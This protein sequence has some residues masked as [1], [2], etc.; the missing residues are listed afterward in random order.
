MLTCDRFLPLLYIEKLC[1][2]VDLLEFIC[3]RIHSLA[4]H[5]AAHNRSFES[6]DTQV[7]AVGGLDNHH[8]SHLDALSGRIPV[9][10]FS[11]I[12]EAH[13]EIILVLFLVYP[14]E[15]VIDLKLAAALTICTLNLATLTPLDYASARTV[16]F[17]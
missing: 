9:D 11:G 5:L 3:F 4:F 17:L 14:R 10:T 12:L 16:I 13:L 15:P 7:V 6:H 1:L 8:V 2:A